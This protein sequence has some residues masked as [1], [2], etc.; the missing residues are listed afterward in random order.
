LQL[1]LREVYIYE[2]RFSGKCVSKSNKFVVFKRGNTYCDQKCDSI[3]GAGSRSGQRRYQTQYRS[4]K[5]PS[6]FQRVNMTTQGGTSVYCSISCLYC[7]I[8]NWVVL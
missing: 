2:L 1:V 6:D 5:A 4:T 8:R 7:S 3:V